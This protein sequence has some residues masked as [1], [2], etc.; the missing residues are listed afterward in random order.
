[1]SKCM[2]EIFDSQYDD[3]GRG[4][5]LDNNMPRWGVRGSRIRSR[6]AG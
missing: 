2:P 6:A 5:Y 1:M 4:D 3:S